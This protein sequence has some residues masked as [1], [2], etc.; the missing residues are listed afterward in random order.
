[1]T[2]FRARRDAALPLLAACDALTVLP[3]DGAFYFYLK[4]PG[5]GEDAGGAFCARLLEEGFV[6][7]ADMDL[8]RL[9]DSPEEIVE[10]AVGPERDEP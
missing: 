7:R 9:S 2:E 6:D 4:V 10:M 1:M 8:F 3:P 5:S